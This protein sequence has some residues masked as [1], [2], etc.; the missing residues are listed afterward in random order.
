MMFNCS[1]SSYADPESYV[2]GGCKFMTFFFFIFLVDEGIEDLNTTISGPSS[3]HQRNAIF[4]GVPMMAQ[5]WM[6]A[7]QFCD[8]QGIQ[9][10]IAKKSYIFVIFSGGSGPP[11]TP[12]PSGFAHDSCCRVCLLDAL[13]VSI[14]AQLGREKD[15]NLYVYW[16]GMSV[17]L[18]VVSLVLGILQCCVFPNMFQY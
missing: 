7:W 15:A 8:F 6:L 2:R 5:H 9:T 12:P 17:S 3:A 4:A 11:A 16:M 13:L 1:S 14:N 18:S 10:S